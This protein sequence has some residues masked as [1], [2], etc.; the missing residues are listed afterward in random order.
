MNAVPTPIIE[1]NETYLVI[2]KV[3][4]NAEIAIRNIKGQYDNAIPAQQATPFP[5][6]K[7]AK[8]GKA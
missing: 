5:P 8:I 6:L 7:S 1:D 3:T 2:S 4:P